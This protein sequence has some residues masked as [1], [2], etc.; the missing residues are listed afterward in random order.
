MRRN[1]CY[2]S[3]CVRLHVGSSV[4]L[5][6]IFAIHYENN[7]I[8]RF[9][10]FLL[11]IIYSPFADISDIGSTPLSAQTDAYRRLH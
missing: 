6:H 1:R 3:V 8:I 10:L 5:Q 9:T 2:N 7:A 4:W 11:S